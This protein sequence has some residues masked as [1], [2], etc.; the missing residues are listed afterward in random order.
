MARIRT[1]MVGGG[2]GGFIGAVHRMA[3]RIDDEFELVA[4]ALSSDPKRAIDSA[5]AIGID[6]RRAYRN[7]QLMAE[8]ES[9]RDDGIEAVVVVTPNDLHADIA[10]TFLKRENHVICDKPLA[11]SPQQARML[12]AAATDSGRLLAVTYN[13]RGYPLIRQARAMCASGCLGRVRLV[14]VEYLQ[15][16]LSEDI[17]NQGSRGALWRTDPSRTGAAG[18]ISD[19]GIHAFDLA[20]FVTGL[21]LEAVKAD[22]TRFVP[23]RL[24]DD[25]ARVLLRFEGGAKGHLWVSQV[26]IG[27]ENDLSLRIYGDQGSLEWQE[28]RPDELWHARLGAPM[29]K[30]TQ[31]GHGL[32]PAAVQASHV[33]AGHSE[34]YVEAFAVVYKELAM[35]IRHFPTNGSLSG[36]IPFANALD[37]LAG[38]NFISAV[39]KS[40]VG[41][42]WQ[43]VDAPS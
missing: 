36:E 42:D 17:E 4:A 5:L 30:L 43:L 33:P 3:M 2:Q 29:Q 23:G 35:V 6:E 15:E 9:Q 26:A 27:N 22:L 14:A 40:S 24:V 31:G 19:I 39:T 10:A 37:G 13:Y 25:D 20:R 38:L 8:I 12:V 32:S 18:A 16:W 34:G 41:T 7:Y 21:R 28:S 11:I 1:G